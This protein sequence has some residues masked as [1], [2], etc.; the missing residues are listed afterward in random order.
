MV[1][2][3]KVTG[4]FVLPIRVYYED[5]DF[6]GI[7]YYANYLKFME[8]G[9]TEFLRSFGIEQDVFREKTNCVFVVRHA[10]I[11]FCRA[12]RFNDQLLVKTRVK[13]KKK[14]SIVFD[15]RVEQYLE[16]GSDKLICAA[17]ITIACINADSF[18]PAK[19]P[20]YL[21]EAINIDY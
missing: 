16:E 3:K 15:Q 8:R 21:V 2:I 9:R 5:T 13:T 18:R 4:E 20:D 7:V 11:D 12:A 19:I 14:A 10:N 6:A 17:D 1:E